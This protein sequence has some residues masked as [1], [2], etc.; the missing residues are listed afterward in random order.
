MNAR[1]WKKTRARLAVVALATWG[2]A[3]PSYAMDDVPAKPA[4][5]AG[6]TQDLIFLSDVRPVLLRMRIDTGAKGFRSS[7]I[8]S[9]KALH[10]YLDKDGN[11]T[12][13]REEADRGGLPTMVRAATGGSAPLPAAD[14][15][16]SPRDGVVSLEELIAV[17]R[18]ALGPFRV[19]VSRNVE[20]KTDALFGHLDRDKDGTLT[21]AELGAAVSSLRRFDLN[22]DELVEDFELDPFSNPLT[23]Q[24]E[25]DNNR[26]GRFTKVQPVVEHSEDDPSTRPLR[27]LLRRYDVGGKDGAA[28]NDNR[29]AKSEFGVDAKDFDAADMDS[30]GMLDTEELRRYLAKA[31]PEIE[32]KVTLP[33]GSK[34]SP[35]IEVAGAGSKPLPPG[36][37]VNR[38][39]QSDVEVAVGDVNLEFHADSGKRAEAEARQYYASAFKAADIDNNMYL[40]KSEVKDHGPFATL[41]SLIDRD[42]DAKVT[43]KEVEAFSDRTSQSAKSQMVL[44][45]A[46]QGR[47]IF[48][49]MDLNR[50]R[51]LGAR[52]IREAVARVSSWDRNGDGV[53]SADEIPHHFQI[54]I[55]PGQATP[56]GMNYS[57]T[58]AAMSSPA[59]AAAPK[60]PVWFQKMDRNKDGD[61]SRRE[62]LGP[63][64]DFDRLDHDGDGLIT[65][66]EAVGAKTKS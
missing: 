17:L 2:G 22:D 9:V 56:V 6:E 8:E 66:D 42:G 38:L 7:W 48:S 60:G 33:E 23:S 40:E 58:N 54:T 24:F 3:V 37:R 46:D 32:L 61:V 14:L 57:A 34:G 62:F 50:D 13:T 28:P 39:S 21:K 43:M 11:G 27:L 19:Q 65:D 5:D 1:L 20:E 64:A 55:G 59:V 51:H 45:T 18:P 31:G 4:A 63:R 26:R 52:E 49:I 53:I 36:V 16:A 30:D 29:L 47:A 12:L 25:E 10:A 41:F 44:T 15:D 35:S